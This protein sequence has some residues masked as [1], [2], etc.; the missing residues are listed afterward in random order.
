MGGNAE[1]FETLLEELK[2]DYL[3]NKGIESFVSLQDAIS[4]LFQ[5]NG[6]IPTPDRKGFNSGF[7]VISIQIISE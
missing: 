7:M 5:K 6:E 3:K 1:N 2:T 4:D